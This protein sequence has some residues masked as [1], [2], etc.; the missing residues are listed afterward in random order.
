MTRILISALLALGLCAAAIAR[1]DQPAAVA[2]AAANAYSATVP[3]A[4]TADA[5]RDAAIS[6]ALADVLKQVAPTIIATPDVL[7]RATGLVRNFRYQRAPSGNGLELQVEFDPGSVNALVQ[8]TEGSAASAATGNGPAPSS[9]AAATAGQGGRGAL[10]VDGIDNAH[11]F[12]SL[13]ALLRATSQLHDVVPV[14]AQGDGVLLDV[15]FDGPLP[16][17]IAGLTGP[18]G[19]LAPGPSA[20]PGADASLRWVP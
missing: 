11:A 12:T 8:Q 4:G 15:T 6:A 3:V 16:G 17:I 9:S 14:A 5:Q 2:A 18:G 1:A 20:H 10:W 13:L 7:S 19:H